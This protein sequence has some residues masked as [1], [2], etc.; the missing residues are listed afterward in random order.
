MSIR[1]IAVDLYKAQKRVH[2]LEARLAEAAINE[3]DAI[4]EELREAEAELKQ[5]RN[6]LE[7]AKSPLPF[8]TSHNPRKNRL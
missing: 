8:K 3:K 6:I 7:G 2:Q 4:R 5:L 1:L